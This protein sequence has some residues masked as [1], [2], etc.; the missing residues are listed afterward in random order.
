[1]A[2][3]NNAFINLPVSDASFDD[4]AKVYAVIRDWVI[5]DQGCFNTALKG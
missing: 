1:M 3:D 4:S 5:P 2:G